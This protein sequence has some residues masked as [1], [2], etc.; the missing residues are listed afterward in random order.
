TASADGTARLWARNGAALR[1]L[2]HGAAVRIASFSDDGSRIVTGSDDGNARIWRIGGNTR[3]IV[4]RHGHAVLAASFSP[5]GRRVVTAGGKFALLWRA[6]GT[7]IRKLTG[8]S[9]GIVDA[10]FS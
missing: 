9:R 4:L 1:T 7:P 10:S 2:Q 5:D 3:P 8:H 6:D